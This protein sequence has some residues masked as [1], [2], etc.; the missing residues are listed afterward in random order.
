MDIGLE[1]WHVRNLYGA[2]SLKTVARELGKHKSDLVC[3][4][5]VRRVKGG[6]ERSM[7]KGMKIIS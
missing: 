6:T 2:G 3:V 7:E 1:T 4:E 5:E